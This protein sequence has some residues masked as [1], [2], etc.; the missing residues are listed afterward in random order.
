MSYRKLPRVRLFLQWLRS[1]DDGQVLS[2]ALIGGF[3]IHPPLPVSLE[4]FMKE[5]KGQLTSLPV[6]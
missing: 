4:T 3:F 2:R 5:R 6:G 1:Q